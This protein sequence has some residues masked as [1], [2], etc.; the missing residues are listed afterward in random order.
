MPKI[1]RVFF[2]LLNQ[3][4]RQTFLVILQHVIELLNVVVH[5]AVFIKEVLFVLLLYLLKYVHLVEQPFN[6]IVSL[7]LLHLHQVVKVLDQIALESLLDILAFA[8]R[9]VDCIKLLLVHVEV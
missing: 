5:F 9:V 8:N 7:V 6:L 1:E 2:F 4:F 3:D